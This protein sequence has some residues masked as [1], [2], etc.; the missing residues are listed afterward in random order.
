M[1]YDPKYAPGLWLSSYTFNENTRC[2]NN[3]W[4]FDILKDIA[5][6]DENDDKIIR[7]Y[8]E[9]DL[10]KAISLVEKE[11]SFS[12]EYDNYHDSIDARV[13]ESVQQNKKICKKGHINTIKRTIQ[14]KC[15][16]GDCRE[17]LIHKS[18]ENETDIEIPT[19][20]ESSEKL[21][22]EH[23]LNVSCF[24]NDNHQ[25]DKEYKIFIFD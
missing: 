16:V 21:R 14:K 7:K 15:K 3:K 18:K 4:D 19:I 13:R 11:T 24:S 6:N 12:D 1:Q 8:F 5:N 2:L 20:E 22:A 25:L 9:N 10:M 17:L 23:Y